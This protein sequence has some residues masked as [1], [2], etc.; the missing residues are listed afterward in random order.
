MRITSSVNSAQFPICILS[1]GDRH[2]LRER[3]D[4]SEPPGLSFPLILITDH[5]RLF[6]RD[7]AATHYFIEHWQECIDLFL[8]VH[9]F[10]HNWQIHGQAKNFGSVQVT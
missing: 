1:Q 9:D 5:F 10:D 7:K 4:Q 6:E 2:A 3:H 8:S